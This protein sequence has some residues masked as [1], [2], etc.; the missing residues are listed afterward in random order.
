MAMTPQKYYCSG[1]FVLKL[2]SQGDSCK[3]NASHFI[4]L[5]LLLPKIA[6]STTQGYGNMI[7]HKKWS[8]IKGIVNYLRIYGGFTF[9]INICSQMSCKLYIQ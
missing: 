3:M 1:P 5:C 4:S 8:H 9:Q 6:R 2:S 7:F